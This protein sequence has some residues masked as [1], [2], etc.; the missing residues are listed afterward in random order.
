MDLASILSYFLVML[1]SVVAFTI[2]V[3][4]GASQANKGFTTYRVALAFMAVGGVL[5][6]LRLAIPLALSSFLANLLILFGMAL[7]VDFFSGGRKVWRVLLILPLPFCLAGLGYFVFGEDCYSSRG[8]SVYPYYVMAPLLT[9]LAILQSGWRAGSLKLRQAGCVLLLV[10][11]SVL[12]T[13]RIWSVWQASTCADTLLT[14]P[15]HPISILAWAIAVLGT[16]FAIVRDPA[17]GYLSQ[18]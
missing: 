5:T 1:A 11:T 4:T 14:S 12:F 17:R 10:V 3:G 13:A 18:T 2:A 6:M 7:Y 16:H 9:G 8:L 15:L